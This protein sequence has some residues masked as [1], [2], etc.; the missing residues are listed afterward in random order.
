MF[1]SSHFWDFL[2]KWVNKE[3]LT[4]LT[5]GYNYIGSASKFPSVDKPK[6]SDQYRRLKW[7]GQC[8]SHSQHKKERTNTGS[9]QGCTCFTLE[10]PKDL[11]DFW[12]SVSVIWPAWFK[13]HGKL[14]SFYRSTFSFSPTWSIPTLLIHT[15]S[16]R[17][18]E[19]TS[20]E[21]T[22]TCALRQAQ[23]I[24]ENFILF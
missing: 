12:M 22:N 14:V 8:Y 17:F 19:L 1:I 18:L 16:G 4:S 11:A 20:K 3:S 15:V 7:E 24:N 2:L 13:W 5:M 9:R 23:V 10:W 21:K 6:E